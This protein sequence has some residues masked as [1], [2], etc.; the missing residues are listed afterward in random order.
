MVFYNK[1]PAQITMLTTRHPLYKFVTIAIKGNYL[2][3]DYQGHNSV[4]AGQFIE[5][6]ENCYLGNKENL[7]NTAYTVLTK[8]L[9]K[10]PYWNIPNF[11]RKSKDLT[12][13]SH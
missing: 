13:S 7:R 1:L 8:I 4:C 6:F 9:Y 3:W 12:K 5:L 2:L 10:T 11:Y